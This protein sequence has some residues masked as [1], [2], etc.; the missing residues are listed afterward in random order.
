MAKL[1]EITDGLNERTVIAIRG[2]KSK[3]PDEGKRQQ[4]LQML[5]WPAVVQ[6]CFTKKELPELGLITQ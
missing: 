4:I 1:L 5:K 6:E 3:E 2:S